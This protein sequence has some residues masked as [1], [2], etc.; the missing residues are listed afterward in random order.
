MFTTTKDLFSIHELNDPAKARN[1]VQSMDMARVR[2]PYF[3][4]K[5]GHRI[6]LN[7]PVKDDDVVELARLLYLLR[8][9]TS[10]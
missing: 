2:I 4:A 9:S 6:H 7:Q 10:L 3:I 5:D 1:Y 8:T